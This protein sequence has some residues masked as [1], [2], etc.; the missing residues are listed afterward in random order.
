MKINLLPPPPPKVRR[1]FLIYWIVVA[2]LV[3]WILQ[4]AI[5]FYLDKTA[6]ASKQNVIQYTNMT[7]AQMQTKI[8]KLQVVADKYN[9][10]QQLLQLRSQLPKP[11][12]AIRNLYTLLPRDGSYAAINYSAGQISTSVNLSSYYEAAAFIVSL[13]NDPVFTNVSVTTISSSATSGQSPSSQVAVSA[14]AQGVEPNLASMI[15]QIA[16]SVG[17][18]GQASTLTPSE[19]STLEALSMLA[20]QNNSS[21]LG[22]SAGGNVTVPF[23]VTIAP[24]FAG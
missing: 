7:I 19:Q 20:K 1:Y 3:L 24:S 22:S 21:L 14:S 2:L 11:I 6:I 5:S 16:H 10:S 8:N 23:T 9:Q 13:Y 15:A 4:G 18:K 17:G 12:E